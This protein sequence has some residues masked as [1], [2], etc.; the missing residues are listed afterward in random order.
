MMDY[1]TIAIVG[2]LNYAIFGFTGVITNVALLV[3]LFR[4]R[5]DN[6]QFNKTLASLAVANVIS[7]VFFA[8]IGTMFSYGIKTGKLQL[9]QARS[10][11]KLLFF[12]K[13]VLM[14]ALSHVV[15]IAIQRFIA[16]HFPIRFRR[17]FTA[18]TTWFYIS[19]TWFVATALFLLSWFTGAKDVKAK[20]RLVSYTI[21][22]F[23]FILIVCYSW[24]IVSLR[25]QR[26]VSRQRRSNGH[27]ASERKHSM[28]LLLNS[29]G[30]TLSFLMLVCPY[31]VSS[32]NGNENVL[33]FLLASLVPI[34]TVIDPLIY[35][36]IS[37]SGK[38]SRHHIAMQGRNTH[39]TSIELGQ[40][41]STKSPS[42]INVTES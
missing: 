31:A 36:F 11:L 23:G 30:V 42:R 40:K 2:C 8:T 1:Q 7:D 13:G 27:T 5:K 41:N 15:F 6:P 37:L 28:K 26:R 9:E 22:I 17:I 25:N 34:R 4:T 38:C 33:R 12:N 29:V 14:I 3:S 10:L 24:I 32:L 35:F 21:I 16:V 20:D 39:N 18:N 19:L